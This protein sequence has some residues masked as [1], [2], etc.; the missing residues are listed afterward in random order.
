MDEDFLTWL[1]LIP[2]I[3]RKRAERLAETFQSPAALQPEGQELNLCPQCGAFV[4]KG[5]TVCPF[6]GTHLEG[7]VEPEVEGVVEPAVDRL[8]PENQGLYLCPNC[9]SMV[10]ADASVCPK[11]GA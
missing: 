2:G 11:C 5:V 7:E 1:L 6:C 9:G 4:G 10:A 8:Q 3:G